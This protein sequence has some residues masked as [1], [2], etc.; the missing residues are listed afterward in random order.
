M[1]GFAIEKRSGAIIVFIIPNKVPLSFII[2]FAFKESKNIAKYEVLL[3]RLRLAGELGV[4]KLKIYND[5]QLIVGQVLRDF[6]A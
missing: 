4:R 2:R 6:Q 3:T 5:S 1:D